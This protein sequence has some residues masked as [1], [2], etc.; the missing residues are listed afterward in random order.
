LALGNGDTFSTNVSAAFGVDENNKRIVTLGLGN[1]FE[2]S[3]AIAGIFANK[4][5]NGNT[6]GWTIKLA[7]GTVQN[8]TQ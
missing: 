7:D 5:E 6:K 8:I 2:I 1:T 4:D 3:E